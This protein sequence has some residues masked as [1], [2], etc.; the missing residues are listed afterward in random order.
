MDKKGGKGLE[1]RESGAPSYDELRR[2]V[3]RTPNKSLQL[4]VGS[5]LYRKPAEVYLGRRIS[6]VVPL[7]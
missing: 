3:D 6:V 4:P 5:R 1:K 2:R 7:V